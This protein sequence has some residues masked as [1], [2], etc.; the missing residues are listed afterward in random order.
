MRSPNLHEPMVCRVAESR[1]QTGKV[2]MDQGCA[3]KEL[4][5]CGCGIARPTSLELF[6]SATALHSW[7]LTRAPPGKTA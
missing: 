1:H 5:G 4:N 6:A 3:V 7:G 2:I